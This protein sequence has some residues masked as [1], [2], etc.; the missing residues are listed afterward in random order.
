MAIALL[1]GALEAVENRRDFQEFAADF[2]VVMIE[3]FLGIE[4][5]GHDLV[6]GFS[7]AG[8]GNDGESS[9]PP[10]WFGRSIH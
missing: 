7:V 5:G 3:D 6:W 4:T 2:E 9:P 1:N 10:R 8:N